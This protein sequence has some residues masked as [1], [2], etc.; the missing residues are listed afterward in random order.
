LKFVSRASPEFW[1]LYNSLPEDVQ[2]QADKQYAL[3][4][5]NPG[6]PS[7]HLKQVGP[8]WSVRVSRSYRA[9]AVRREDQF[10]WFWIGSHQEYERLL[11]GQGS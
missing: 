11:K 8:F 6:H 7:L 4:V 9:M 2:A 5:D 10:F 1:T 3:F